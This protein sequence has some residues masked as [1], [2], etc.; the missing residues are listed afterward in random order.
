M[1]T[2][3]HPS[4]IYILDCLLQMGQDVQRR[5]LLQHV[6]EEVREPEQRR[7]A[8]GRTGCDVDG[9]PIKSFD[10]IYTKTVVA[11]KTGQSFTLTLSDN[12]K[13]KKGHDGVTL[14][15]IRST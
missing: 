7:G 15:T 10:M 12:I 4:M 1:P 11:T 14:H 13:V 6:A 8:G 3:H 5:I 2:Q 9:M